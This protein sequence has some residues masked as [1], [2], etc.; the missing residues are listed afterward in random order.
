MSGSLG[1][2][3]IALLDEAFSPSMETR[4]KLL[5]IYATNPDYKNK[6]KKK[7]NQQRINKNYV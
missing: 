3:C 1:E 4:I 2:F 7:E 6:S 5:Y